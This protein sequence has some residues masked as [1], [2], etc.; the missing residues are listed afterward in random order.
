MRLSVLQ[1]L[2]DDRLHLVVRFLRNSSLL[3]AKLS[4]LRSE[5]AHFFAKL[6]HPARRIH[7][8]FSPICPWISPIRDCSSPSLSWRSANCSCVIFFPWFA[9]NFA[10]ASSIFAISLL[11]SGVGTLACLLLTPQFFLLFAECFLL[12]AKVFLLRSQ[13]LHRLVH[14]FDL[15][16]DRRIIHEVRFAVAREPE[17]VAVRLLARLLDL[18]VLPFNPVR[19][20]SVMCSL[21]PPRI[22]AYDS[23]FDEW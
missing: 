2:I 13:C 14:R 7:P 3:R 1:A 9:F 12:L 19:P 10:I 15:C 17:E 6:A 16:Q 18:F 20:K 4:H 5:C 8:C 23:P 11:M 21:S 22:T